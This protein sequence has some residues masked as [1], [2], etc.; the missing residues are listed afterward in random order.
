MLFRS[1]VARGAA[2]TNRE[3]RSLFAT[4][5]YCIAYGARCAHALEPDKRFWEDD[6]WPYLLRTEGEALLRS[7]SIFTRRYK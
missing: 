5:V 7:E 2:F 6:T 1:E 3:R 4:S